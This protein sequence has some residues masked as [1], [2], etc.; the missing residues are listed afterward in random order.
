MSDGAAGPLWR[1]GFDTF[2]GAI[3][4]R[5]EDVI[6]TENFAVAAGL[7][8]QVRRTMQRTTERAT[9]RVL[10]SLNLPAG[11]DVNRILSE[12]GRL[13]RQVTSL[14]REVAAAEEATRAALSS[15]MKPAPRPAKAT[16]RSSNRTTNGTTRGKGGDDARGT[17]AKRPAR[18][19]EA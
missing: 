5:L 9:R 2:E 13:E 12:L 16:T 8:V 6:E 18:S 7:V 1:R 17:R 3:R 14:K 19:T 10:H 15:A 11:S 4:P